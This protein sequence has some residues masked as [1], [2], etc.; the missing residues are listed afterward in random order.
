MKSI[1][2]LAREFSSGYTTK[3]EQDAAFT[4]Y[5]EAYRKGKEDKHSREDWDLSFADT[6]F[7]PILYDWFCYKKER[8]E[9]YK[10]QRSMSAC[11]QKLYHL[12]DG[13]ANLAKQI[14][15]QSMGNNWAGLFELKNNGNRN[16]NNKQ[17]NSNSIFQAAD[18]YLQEHQ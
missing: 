5:C 8:K 1:Q 3:P 2:E 4:A 18:N 9:S 6:A 13:D 14:I 12:S 10:G 16:I 15:M 7:Q 11:Y 17:G